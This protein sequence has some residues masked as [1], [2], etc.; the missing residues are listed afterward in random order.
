MSSGPPL[1]VVVDAG[2]GVVGGKV[3]SFGGRVNMKEDGVI[4]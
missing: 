2:V 3:A 1:V 4:L